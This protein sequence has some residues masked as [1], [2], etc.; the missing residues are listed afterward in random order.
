MANPIITALT[1]T[2]LVGS[3]GAAVVINTH[4]LDQVPTKQEQVVVVVPAEETDP[5]IVTEVIPAEDVI[6]TDAEEAYEDQEESTSTVTKPVDNKPQADT[7]TGGSSV[8]GGYDDED[9]EDENEEDEHEDEDEYEEE[10][11]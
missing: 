8:S 4:V 6:I 5:I 10:D 3:T 11:D 1:I 7:S 9:E 2:G